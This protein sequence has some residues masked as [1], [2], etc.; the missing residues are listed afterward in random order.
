MENVSENSVGDEENVGLNDDS[1][2]TYHLSHISLS[3]ALGFSKM[4]MSKTQ[5]RP[6]E[7]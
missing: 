7:S 1:C 4:D 5:C 3:S 2:L 6:V